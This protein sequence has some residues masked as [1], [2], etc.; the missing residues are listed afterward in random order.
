[1]EKVKYCPICRKQY[2]LNEK[3]CDCGY[4]FVVKE[5]NEEVVA[6]NTKVIYDN[7]PLGLWTFLGFISLSI[8]G[9][10]LF[11]KWR[12]SYPHRSKAAL[13]GAISFIS[14]VLLVALVAVLYL[15]LDHFGKIV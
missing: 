3:K 4:E 10:V 12:S 13:K 9:F 5:E 7:K 8:A 14:I 6:T 15:V 1:M 11:F 2:N